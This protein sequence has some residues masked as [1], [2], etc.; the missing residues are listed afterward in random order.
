MYLRLQCEEP[1]YYISEKFGNDINGDGSEEY[2]FKTL[3]RY[4]EANKIRNIDI[5]RIRFDADERSR[6]RWA[7]APRCQIE[8]AFEEYMER[9]SKTGITIT[10]IFEIS[11]NTNL[12]AATSSKIRDLH[13]HI[14]ERVKVFGWVYR[15]RR[16]SMKLM[17]LVL[18][19]GTGL[20]QCVLADKLSQTADGLTLSTGSSIFVKGIVSRMTGGQTAPSD[21]VLHVDYWERLE[22]WESV[23]GLKSGFDADMQLDSRHLTIQNEKESKILRVISAVTSAFRDH[24]KACGFREV[25]PPTVMQ[26]ELEGGPRLFKFDNCGEPGYLTQSSQLHLETCVPYFGDCYCM[27]GHLLECLC[28]EAESPFIEMGDLMD[29]IEDLVCDVTQRVMEEAGDLVMEI[30]PSFK[31]VP[32][33]KFKRMVKCEIIPRLKS[34]KIFKEDGEPFGYHDDIP[35]KPRRELA[36]KIGLPILMVEFPTAKTF[37]MQRFKGHP[38]FS[39]C[40]SLLMPGVGEILGGSV[41]MTEIKDLLADC[42]REGMDS[43]SCYRYTEQREF[44]ACSHGGYGLDFEKFCIWLLGQHHIRDVCLY[45]RCKP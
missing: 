31:A 14:G 15:I 45:P 12:P 25:H 17:F 18:C 37:Y 10:R 6:E 21:I 44:G 29:Q 1:E 36:D 13:D 39:K 20:L 27:D 7:D 19:D 26:T 42:E 8:K 30:N 43:D 34:E 3:D 33:K 2:P 38:A 9:L 5:I 24:Y 35:E 28:I 22:F 32:K 11:E 16:E 40:V 23:A 4:F 41:S